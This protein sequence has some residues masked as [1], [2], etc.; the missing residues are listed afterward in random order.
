MTLIEYQDEHA[1]RLLQLHNPL[2]NV[3]GA[4]NGAWPM[5]VRAMLLYERVERLAFDTGGNPYRSNLPSAIP[6][7]LITGKLDS[8]SRV[9]FAALEDAISSF[10]VE[11]PPLPSAT[12]SG[13]DSA[14]SPSGNRNPYVFGAHIIYQGTVQLLYSLADDV[15]ITARRRVFDAARSLGQL[16]AQLRG[17]GVK[18]VQAFLSPVVSQLMPISDLAFRRTATLFD[19][20]FLNL[21]TPPR[22]C[23]C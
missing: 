7:G 6:N 12:S 23:T 21:A 8:E 5:R 22:R 14:S 18:D 16:A 20:I 13:G 19:T 17:D 3:S 4:L 15:D 2:F 10:K 1:L 11:L 9:T